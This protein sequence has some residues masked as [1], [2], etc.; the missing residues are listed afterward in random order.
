MLV[1]NKLNNTYVRGSRL[2]RH[3]SLPTSRFLTCRTFSSDV[4][5]SRERYFDEEETAKG[6]PPMPTAWR[7][8]AVHFNL[9]KLFKVSAFDN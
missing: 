8:K 5:R 9:S 3:Q 1:V 7:N 6:G 4:F 2:S